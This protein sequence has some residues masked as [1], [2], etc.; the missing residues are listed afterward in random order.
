M[1]KIAD[2]FDVSVDYLLD[3]KT[4]SDAPHITPDAANI[5]RYYNA[6]SDA[7]KEKAHEY[8][9]MLCVMESQKKD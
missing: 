8:L 7:G 4:G 3:R 5:L 2:Y 6:L 1:V 9:Q